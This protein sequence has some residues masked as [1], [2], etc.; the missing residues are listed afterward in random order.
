MKIISCSGTQ[1]D[2]I[3]NKN[4]VSKDTIRLKSDSTSIA[5]IHQLK[6][7]VPHKLLSNPK[8]VRFEYTDSTSVC[9]RNIISDIT[10]YDS[11]N[12]VAE[13]ESFSSNRF[14]FLFTAKNRQIKAEARASMIKHLKPGQDLPLQPLH[15]DWIIGIVILSA[16]VYSLVRSSSKSMMHGISRFF[17]FKGINDS[18]SRD[19]DGLFAG[20]SKILN[21]ISFLNIG[22]FAYCAASYY[23]V[24]P[25]GIS[26]IVFWLLCV[27]IFILT[28]ILRHIVCIITGFMSGEKDAFNEYL[29]GI[30]QSYRLSALFLFI[31][32]ILMLYTM[33]LHGSGC[34]IAGVAV[35]GIFYLLRIF[36]LL[37]IFLKMNIS[38]FYLILYLCALEFLPVVIS[39]KYF[40]GL[41]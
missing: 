6:D 35:L 20:Q 26:G 21:L 11:S 32:V 24:I 27:G 10:F 14:P 30:Y 23:D 29:S 13:I 12:I 9:S 4:I 34:F 33:I 19:K 18:S 36:R 2:T 41:V 37:I 28:V 39:V 1:Q 40:T 38:I 3:P 22:L 16:F 5:N 25:A 17:L 15:D 31:L 8:P 7:S